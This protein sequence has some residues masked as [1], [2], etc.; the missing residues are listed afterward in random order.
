MLI[1]GISRYQAEIVGHGNSDRILVAL[2]VSKELVVHLSLPLQQLH[3]HGVELE[4]E[5]AG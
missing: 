5:V 4:G 3:R 1:Q 2:V